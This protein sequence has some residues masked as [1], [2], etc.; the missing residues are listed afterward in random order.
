MIYNWHEVDCVLI[1]RDMGRVV[2]LVTREQR[3]AQ[4]MDTMAAYIRAV[5]MGVITR[6]TARPVATEVVAAGVGNTL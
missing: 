2:R 6:A 4:V 1:A 3:M 5:A